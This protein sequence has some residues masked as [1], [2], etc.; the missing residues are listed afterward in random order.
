MPRGSAMYTLLGKQVL[1]VLLNVSR[2]RKVMKYL[3]DLEKSQWWPRERILELQSEKLKKLFRHA[4]ENVFWYRQ[5]F[6]AEGLKPA[7]IET[8]SDLAK[9]PI[10]TKQIVR[11]NSK[12]MIARGFSDEEM[13]LT[14][15]GGSTGEPLEFFLL[16]DHH[17]L[18]FAKARRALCWWGYSPGDRFASIHMG[19]PHR[20]RMT[21]L[22][23]HLE[24]TKSF[25]PW[26]TASELPLF[27]AEME[28]FRPKV[29]SGYPSLIYL[30]AR[31]AEERGRNRLKPEVIIIHSEGLYE[32]QRDAIKRVFGC[33]IYSHYESF[34]FDQI[35]AECPEHAGQH[36]AA[37]SVIVEA[38]DTT[39]CTV[40]PGKEGRLL[41]TDLHNYA[42]PFIRYD[43]GDVGIVSEEVCHCGRGLPLL[44]KLS[45]RAMDFAVTKDGRKI[46]GTCFLATQVVELFTTGGVEQFQIVQENYGELT[47]RVVLSGK[48]SSQDMD[49][50]RARIATEYGRILGGGMAVRVEVVDRIA[51]TREGKRHVFVSK[52]PVERAEQSCSED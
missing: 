44:T 47:V 20:S 4:Y 49:G 46:P 19:N 31:F 6:E 8:I 24:R 16:L 25:V 41:I 30:L 10:V 2:G 13:V 9:L 35:A 36:I 43:I 51:S 48:M 39:G 22:R 28:R 26:K 14:R 12:R 1:G 11:E 29:I 52:L 45:G 37:E 18:A 5:A 23:R 33:E 27:L 3:S 21:R 38:V 15:T 7:N 40:G 17:N 34:E 50:L 32:F 42:M